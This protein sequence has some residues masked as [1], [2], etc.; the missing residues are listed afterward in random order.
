MEDLRFSEK[1]RAD[2]RIAQIG[3]DNFK[4]EVRQR[5]IR[6]KLAKRGSDERHDL[7]ARRRRKSSRRSTPEDE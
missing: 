1:T 6:D 2:Q 3:Y 5:R 7:G 4:K